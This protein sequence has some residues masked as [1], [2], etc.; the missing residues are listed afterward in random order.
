ML[1]ATAW[2]N[3]SEFLPQGFH[4]RLLPVF[5]FIHGGGFGIGSHAWPQSNLARTVKLSAAS[6][7]YHYQVSDGIIQSVLLTSKVTV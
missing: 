6:D 2:I 4:R 1:T 7:R 5:V 3:I